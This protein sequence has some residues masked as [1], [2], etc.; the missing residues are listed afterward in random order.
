MA[1]NRL[2][3]LKYKVL[4]LAKL[5]LSFRKRDW[6]LLDYP[7]VIK[8]SDYAAFSTDSPLYKP[9]PYSAFIVNWGLM[10]MGDT[11]DEAL[12]ALESTFQKV[13]L[14]RGQ[15]AE[16]LPR[17]GVSVPIQVAP[18]SRVDAHPELAE[19]FIQ[20]VLEIDWALI[21]D[22]SSLWDFNAG[23]NNAPLFARIKDIYGIDVSDIQSARLCEI[24]ERIAAGNNSWR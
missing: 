3:R 17:P 12:S 21:T 5:G 18:A 15:N 10:G 14:E 11:K 9:V 13:K 7:V 24:F 19:D 1:I 4:A 6:Q 2:T 20:R 8:E 23:E 16:P 22:E